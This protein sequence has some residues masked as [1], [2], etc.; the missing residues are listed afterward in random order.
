[1]TSGN[2]LYYIASRLILIIGVLILIGCNEVIP[3]NPDYISDG[4]DYPVGKPN[5]KG[6]YD[7]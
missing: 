6:Y 5:A 1:M 7:A 2:K 4:F 3:T